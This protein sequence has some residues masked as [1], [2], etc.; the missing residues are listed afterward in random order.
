MSDNTNKINVK[1]FV[2]QILDNKK[3]DYITRKYI[4][5]KEKNA[6]IDGIIDV[7]VSKYDEENNQLLD[8][9]DLEVN[10]I[11]D[12]V[13]IKVEI[14]KAYTNLDTSDRQETYD[15]LAEDNLLDRIFSDI[16]RDAEVFENWF[17]RKKEK[18]MEF[19]YGLNNNSINSY[20]IQL[21]QKEIEVQ[22]LQKKVLEETEK[23]NKDYTKEDI[24]KM[25]NV[26]A[27]VNENFQNPEYIKAVADVIHK[28]NVVK[29]PKTPQDHKKKQT[30]KKK[31]VVTDKVGE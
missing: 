5:V 14:L 1:D 27:A 25:T 26:F 3:V 23:M 12:E 10:P 17:Y 7:L 30:S 29:L 16:G 2:A 28:E 13:F 6:I 9:Y 22:E 31:A 20:V 15:L 11:Y 8:E 24:E 4:P 18:K 19:L 21:I